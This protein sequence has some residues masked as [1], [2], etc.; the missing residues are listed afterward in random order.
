MP[1]IRYGEQYLGLPWIFDITDSPAPLADPG[2]DKGRQHVELA[3]SQDLL[4]WSRP[5]RANLITPGA[6]GSWDWGWDMTGTTLL[7]VGDQVRLYYA[8]FAGQH[9]CS[10]AD[11]SAGLCTTP[12]GNARVGLVTW[13]K[14]RFESFHAST[15][16]GEVTTRTLSPSGTR[17][18]VNAA[19]GSG[20]LRVEVLDAD[21][22]PVPGYTAADAT[23][24]TTDT[25]ATTVSWGSKTT[26]PTGPIRLRFDLTAGDLYSYT[27]D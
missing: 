24:I 18:T 21:G 19:P 9:S 22:K 13:P 27:I 20:A 16:G 1:A 4:T 10:A 17:L 12:F 26:L 14:D 15:G 11:V 7:T 6:A 8:A 25:L 3:S 5:S 2:P 23:P